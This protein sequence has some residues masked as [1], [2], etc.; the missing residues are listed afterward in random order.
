MS[1]VGGMMEQA[2]WYEPPDE[3]EHWPECEAAMD[4]GADCSCDMIEQEHA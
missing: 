4:D 2:G 1:D 3:P